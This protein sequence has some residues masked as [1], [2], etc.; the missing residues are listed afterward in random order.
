MDGEDYLRSVGGEALGGRLRRL[1]ERIDRDAA[2]AYQALGIRF[3][4]RWFGLINQLRL[5]GPMT[6]TD[7]AQAIGISHASV[8]QARQSLERSGYVTGYADEADGRRRLI[9][10]TNQGEKLVAR[11]ADVWAADA[12][13]T[14][15]LADSIEGLMDALDALEDALAEKP[16][17]ERAQD[18]LSAMRK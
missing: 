13:A 12:R 5:N 17:S 4:Q 7:I 1:S 16:L 11:L 8:S 10:L 3:E 2:K 9:A 6:V 15:K 18:E 14:R